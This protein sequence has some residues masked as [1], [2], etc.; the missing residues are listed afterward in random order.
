MNY[1]LFES[2]DHDLNLIFLEEELK[3]FLKLWN[4]NISLREIASKM[5]R[6]TS[7]VALL[8]FDHAERGLIEQRDRS[9]HRL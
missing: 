7:E 4:E 3:V 8:V 9:L 2:D 1:F 6:K 5:K